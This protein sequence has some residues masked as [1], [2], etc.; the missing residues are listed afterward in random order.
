MTNRKDYIIEIKRTLGQYSKRAAHSQ[1][2]GNFKSIYRG[3]SMEFDDLREYAYGDDYADIEWKASMRTGK[4]LVKR[5]IA[6]KQ[7]NVL[8][9]VDTGPKMKAD[10]SAHDD[11][12]ETALV[13]AGSIAYLVG[14]HGD[15]FAFL[16]NTESGKELTRFSTD[17]GHL[18]HSLASC[19]RH[20]SDAHDGSV[21]QLLSHAIRR[22]GRHM[23]IFV[24]TDLEGAAGMSDTVV[25]QALVGNDLLVML[26]DDAFLSDKGAYDIETGEYMP[27]MFGAGKLAAEE[28]RQRTQVFS[29]ISEMLSRNGAHLS[30]VTGMSDVADA[31]ISLTERNARNGGAR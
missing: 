8:V 2:A 26:V 15:N 13:S 6:E 29:N 18:E 14:K 9:I 31:I 28:R 17:T 23:V 1:F 3:K 16:F 24:V 4:L 12:A 21:S 5:F 11:K 25:K 19:D 22:I 10:T 30:V 27:Q 20:M 7:H